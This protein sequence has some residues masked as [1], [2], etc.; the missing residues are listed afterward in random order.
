M[1]HQ[2]V[3]A[4]GV[5]AQL[6]QPRLQG[7]PAGRPAKAGVD[8]QVGVLTPD[9]ITVELPEWIA[10]KGHSDPIDILLQFFDHD[11]ASP[12]FLQPIIHVSPLPCK[13]GIVRPAFSPSFL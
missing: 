10:R 9:K 2:H 6:L 13:S 4:A 1:G 5:A 7:L 11:P 12:S 8:E 3:P